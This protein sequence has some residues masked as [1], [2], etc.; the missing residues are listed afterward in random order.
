MAKEKPESHKGK[1]VRW[2]D[3]RQ[4]P[5]EGLERFEDYL[6]TYSRNRNHPLKIL[7]SF[8]KGHQW[9]MLQACL[10]LVVQRSPVWVIPIATANIINAA[11][12]VSE[13]SMETILINLVVALLFIL[14]NAGSNYLAAQKYA[15]VNRSIEGSLRNAMV[16]KLQQLSIMFHKEVQSGRLQSKI[17]R[18]VENVTELLNQIFRVLFFFVLDVTVVVVMTLRKSPVV[19]LFFL[20]VVPF[21]VIAMRSFKKPIAEKNRKFRSEMEHTQGAV[22]EMLEMI[23]VARAHGL[24]EVEIHKMNTHLNKIENSGYNLDVIIALFGAVNWVIFQAFQILCL[25][26]TAFLACKG[27]ISVGEVVLYQTYFG[28]LVSQISTLLNVYPQITRGLE[29]VKSI[30]DIMGET[31]VEENHSIVPLGELK[32]KVEFVNVDFKYPD[33]EKWILNDVSLKV[34]AGESVAFV[35]ESG[36]GKSTIL[37]LLIGFVPPAN[38]RILIDGIN[39]AN[40]DLNEYRHQIAV[41]PQNTILFSGTIIDNITYGLENVARHEVEEVIREVGLWELVEKLPDGLDTQLGE[42]GDKLSGGQRQR[43]SIARALI[44]KPKIIVFDE[45]TSALDSASEKKVQEATANMMK[46]CTTFLVAHRLSTIRNADRIVAMKEGHIV[47]VGTYEELM[48]KKGYF[49]ELKSLQS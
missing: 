5:E 7:C 21:V 15:S 26:F 30:G 24:Q 34:E 32:G 48:E 3:K 37:N 31:K 2:A 25:A 11:T 19:F 6:E 45:A 46:N 22:A 8:Y 44:R 9:Q 20:I 12:Y 35:G 14:Q 18:D 38:G 39:M 36:A 28:S 43:I 1:R 49:Y 16:R 4:I 29:S 23:P 10:F 17:M 40:L 41:V 33:S 27:Q 47:E 13:N 42:H